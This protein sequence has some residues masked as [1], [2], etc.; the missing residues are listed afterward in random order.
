MLHPKELCQL[1]YKRQ[2]KAEYPDWDDSMVM[3][4]N[5]VERHLPD[6]AIVLDAGC[7]HGNFVIDELRPR[8][9]RAVGVD[10][11]PS[12]TSKNVCL[13]EIVFGRLEQLPFLD[14]TFDA[15]ISLWVLEH[16]TDPQKVFLEMARVLKPGGFFA[17]VTPSKR[18]WLIILRRL[19]SQRIV[20]RIVEYLYGR[21]EEDVFSVKYEVNSLRDIR[22]VAQASGLQVEWLSENPDPTYTSFGAVSYRISA[23]L[24]RLPFSLFRVHVVGILRKPA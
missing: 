14:G 21:Q 10:V 11:H 12:V 24:S 7:G 2:Y 13:D 6:Q 15:V 8:M 18:S 17:F 16:I 23:F 19:M 22:L 1:R 9:G 4:R 3:L 20:D 5:L